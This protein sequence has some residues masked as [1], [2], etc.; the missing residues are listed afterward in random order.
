MARSRPTPATHRIEG[1]PTIFANAAGIDMGADQ[2]VVAVPP[3]R[4]PEPVRRFRTFTADLEAL[5]AWLVST[6]LGLFFTLSTRGN[7]AAKLA[8]GPQAV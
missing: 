2:I 5:V 8:T 3:D 1:L 4:D 6:G 7:G